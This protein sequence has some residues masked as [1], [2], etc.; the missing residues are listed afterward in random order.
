MGTRKEKIKKIEQDK[1]RNKIE[2]TEQ[3]KEETKGKKYD[4]DEK[5]ITETEKRKRSKRRLR[6]R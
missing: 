2:N 1:E 6:N 5:K 3:K 4:A